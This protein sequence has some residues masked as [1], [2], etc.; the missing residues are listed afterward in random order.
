MTVPELSE[1]VQIEAYALQLGWVLLRKGKASAFTLGAIA[2]T[3]E[4]S[5]NGVT[6]DGSVEKVGGAPLFKRQWSGSPLDADAWLRTQL[7]AWSISY[8]QTLN[9]LT[10][11]AQ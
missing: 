10:G 7:R 8:V 4:F 2:I 11:S 5:D 3:A 1:Q 9:N 6:I